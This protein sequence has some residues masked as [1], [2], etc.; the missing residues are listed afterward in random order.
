MGIQISG[1]WR[2]NNSLPLLPLLHAPGF[3][4]KNM[5][6]KDQN[7]VL[8]C[9]TLWYQ[10]TFCTCSYWRGRRPGGDHPSYVAAWH[11]FCFFQTNVSADLFIL[12]FLPL[13]CS[14][15]HVNESVS[16]WCCISGKNILVL[17]WQP[18]IFTVVCCGMVLTGDFTVLF[19]SDQN[20]LHC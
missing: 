15:F 11:L 19:F 20:T 9:K 13:P 8:L 17:K 10:W 2:E 16:D 7:R 18:L 6:I 4:H 14:F 12:P 3:R 1:E 5:N